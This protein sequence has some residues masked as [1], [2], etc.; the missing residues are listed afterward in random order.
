MTVKGNKKNL[1]LEI[2]KVIGLTGMIIVALASSPRG[3]AV[4]LEGLDEY[5]RKKKLKLA[6]SQF[7]KYLWYLRKKKYVDIV[8]EDDSGITIKIMG[9]GIERIK[10]FDLESLKIEPM[11]KWDQKWRVVIFDIPTS[12]KSARDALRRKLESLGFYR[13]Q[14]SIFVIPWDCLDEIV[15]LRKV[16]KIEPHVSILVA[17]AIDEEMR[18]RRLFNIQHF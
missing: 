17:D 8:K 13:L 16:F 2:L 5:R 4:V 12:K 1:A 11:K 3:A 6:R 15:F 14:K 10:K 18:L 7:S 9:R